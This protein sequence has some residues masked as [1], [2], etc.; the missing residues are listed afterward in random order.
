VLVQQK[1]GFDDLESNLK[2]FIQNYAQGHRKLEGLFMDQTT[3]LKREVAEEHTKTRTYIAAEFESREQ[4]KATGDEWKQLL[5]SL[6]FPTMTARKNR[7]AKAHEATFDWAFD[8]SVDGRWHSLAQWMKSDER[9]FWISGKPGSG[10]ST[11]MKFLVDNPRTK[12]HLAS[13]NGKVKIVSFFLWNSGT[14]QQVAFTESSVLFS[15]RFS[16]SAP[17]LSA[18]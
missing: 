12:Q 15:T 14:L 6:Q 10:K 3:V 4:A 1:A 7:V 16:M 17:G 5:E 11:L 2:V 18:L 8:D 13:W 9:I